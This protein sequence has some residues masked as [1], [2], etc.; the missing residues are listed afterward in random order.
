[1]TD[2]TT[3]VCDMKPTSST[4]RLPMKNGDGVASSQ[5]GGKVL[6]VDKLPEFKRDV[7]PFL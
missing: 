4:E 1:M 6:V 2:K 5:Y 3:T 7:L